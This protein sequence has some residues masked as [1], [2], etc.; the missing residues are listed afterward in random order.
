MGRARPE[1]ILLNDDDLAYAKIRLD[2]QSRQTAITHLAS[3]ENPLA[4]ALVWGS[5]WDAH[6][7][8]E[9]PAREFLALVLGNIASE[10]ESTTIRTVLA[11]AQTSAK[12]FSAPAERAEMLREL[13]DE[14]WNL[15]L[16]AQP[17]SDSQFQLVKNFAAIAEHSSRID[18]LADLFTEDFALDGLNIDTDLGW[19]LLI[20]LA[21]AGRADESAIA[22]YLATDNT[23]TGAQSAAHAR[24]AIPTAVAKQQAWDS[25]VVAD[26]APNTIVRT[27]ALGFVRGSDEVLSPFVPRYFDMLER[28][29]DERSFA[30]AEAIIEGL[31]P[32]SLANTSLRDA[33][34]QWLETHPNA[35]AALRRI[36]IENLASVERALT[37]QACDTAAAE[38]S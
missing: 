11:Q 36:I 13:A 28:I 10:T 8:G 37:A 12:Q 22:E 16:A 35:P 7:D 6:R 32:F 20:A 2:E 9:I 21:A 5:M 27:T 18:A 30:I 17:D 15:A 1:L 25:L 4:R 23:A 14:L 19:E 3:I 29:W 38:R 31:F 33:S 26:D 34:A 24:A